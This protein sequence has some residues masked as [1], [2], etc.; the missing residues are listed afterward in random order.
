MQ[1]PSRQQLIKLQAW[2]HWEAL[3]QQQEAASR[4]LSLLLVLPL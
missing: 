2:G 3:L 4:R 1:Q